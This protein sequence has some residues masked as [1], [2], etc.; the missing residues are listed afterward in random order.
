MTNGHMTSQAKLQTPRQRYRES[1]RRQILD[2]AREALM[3]DGYDGV[4]MRRVA[5]S[6]GCTHGNLYLHFKDKE[7]L[8]DCLVEEAFKEFDAGM[9][10]T[11]ESARGADPVEL[12]RKLG[13]AYVEFGVANP[14]V[15]EF[16]FVLPRPGS[17]RRHKPHA[18][19]YRLEDL[20]KRCIDAKRFRKMD[21]HVASQSLWAAVHGITSL[22]VVRPKFP[23]GDR[24]KVI[25]QVVD[26]AV[27]GLVRDS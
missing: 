11:A 3:R 4:S 1:L 27:D 23:W 21:V 16:A 8:F 13:R 5:E 18:T 6:V 26:A 2:A 19:Y 17:T 7:A 14:A 22:L 9:H 12:V 15:Y 20:V 25:A 10:K 24:Q